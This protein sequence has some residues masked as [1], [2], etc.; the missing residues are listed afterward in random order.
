MNK[1]LNI[2]LQAIKPCAAHYFINKK[3]IDASNKELALAEWTEVCKTRGIVKADEVLASMPKA[4]V[5]RVIFMDSPES[6]EIGTNVVSITA[7]QVANLCDSLG[8]PTASPEN[9]LLSLVAKTKASSDASPASCVVRA[10]F[11]KAGDEYKSSV[12]GKVM[13][14]AVDSVNISISDI[15]LPSR[16]QDAIAM[17][18][19]MPSAAVAALDL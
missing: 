1:N 4:R 15:L 12:S 9:R 2:H 19:Y 5:A 6:R 16:V 10:E 3:S 18:S 17:K 7:D 14:C 13:K 11:R 8:I